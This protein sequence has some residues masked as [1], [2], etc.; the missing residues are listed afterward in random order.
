MKKL[1]HAAESFIKSMGIWDMAAL[2]FCVCAA[3]IIIG[4]FVPKRAKKV[5]L[6]G[7][8][9]VFAATYIPLM[10]KFFRVLA[11]TIKSEGCTFPGIKRIFQNISIDNKSKGGTL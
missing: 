4:L 6:F 2:K 1:F 5:V 7:T 9:G 8:A 3:G 10:V 11:R